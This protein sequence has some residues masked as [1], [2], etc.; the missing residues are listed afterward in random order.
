MEAKIK[1][2]RLWVC[3]CYIAW[4]GHRLSECVCLCAF[5]IQGF[6]REC[7]AFWF[8][9][10]LWSRAAQE[11]WLVGWLRR[12]GNSLYQ[13]ADG[14]QHVLTLQKHTHKHTCMQSLHTCWANTVAFIKSV[15]QNAVHKRGRCGESPVCFEVFSGKERQ[16]KVSLTFQSVDLLTFHHVAE[17]ILY[18]SNFFI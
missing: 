13:T 18:P 1:Q 17:T 3:L 4:L 9:F 11:G 10:P 6:C 12:K 15:T 16:K 8:P 5:L 7:V 2:R 14:G